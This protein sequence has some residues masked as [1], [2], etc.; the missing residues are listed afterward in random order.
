MKLTTT[1]RQKVDNGAPFGVY[2]YRCDDGEVLGD[3]DGNV[4][5]VFGMRGDREAV[6]KVYIAARHYGFTEGKVEFWPGQRPVTD[7]EYEEQVTRSKLGLVPDTMDY[8]AIMDELEGERH[9]IS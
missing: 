5:Q 2:V 1:S 7:E 4:M 3:G 6:K 8:G 9:G